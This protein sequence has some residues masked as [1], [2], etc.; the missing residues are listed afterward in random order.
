MILAAIAAFLIDRK[1]YTAAVWSL[2]AAAFAALGLTHAYQVSGNVVD[3][4]FIFADPH[5]GA[6]PTHTFGIAVGYLLFAGVFGFFGWYVGR[7]RQSEPGEL[8]LEGT[9]TGEGPNRQSL[10]ASTHEHV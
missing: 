4:L 10:I 8:R 1:F 6:L 2:I 7:G 9:I 5:P 3:F